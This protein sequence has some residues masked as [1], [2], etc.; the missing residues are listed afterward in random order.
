[1]LLTFLSPSVCC[2]LLVLIVVGTRIAIVREALTIA[3]E[4]PSKGGKREF[5][6]S[7]PSGPS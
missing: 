7:R 6:E 2:F 4:I 1:M 5:A 3:T